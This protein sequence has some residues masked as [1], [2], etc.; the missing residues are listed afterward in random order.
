M[1][2]FRRHQWLAFAG[3]A[4]VVV[5]AALAA[6]CDSRNKPPQR[7][8]VVRESCAASWVPTGRTF[9]GFANW[10]RTSIRI[11]PIT[12]M[13]AKTATAHRDVAAYGSVK[14]RTLVRPQTPVTVEIGQTA[15]SAVGFVSTRDAGR[16]VWPAHGAPILRLA[17]C[18]ADFP[19]IRGL[20]AI[21]YG[22]FLRVRHNA[23]VP[24]TVGQTRRTVS[25]GAG[26][27]SS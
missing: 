16:S 9:V 22:M 15:R 4:A 6:G 7:L 14:F 5:A 3:A 12:L 27:C 10:R 25:I 8:A 19:P 20:L 1:E 24:L 2:G 26:R 18:R 23:C 11:G 17:P 13:G 21:G